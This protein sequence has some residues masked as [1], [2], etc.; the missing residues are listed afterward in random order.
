MTLGALYQL[1]RQ[2]LTAAGV[3]SPEFDAGFLLRHFLGVD[4]AG[5]ILRRE[6][7]V[8]DADAAPLLQALEMRA[9]RR[10]LQYVA[11]VWPFMELDLRVGEGV[12]VPRE[13]TAVLVRALADLLPPGRTLTGVDLCAGSGA[14]ALGLCSL[15]PDLSVTAVELSDAA[16]G[17]L[18][19]NAA[20]YPQYHVRP[21]IGDVTDPT[22]AQAFQNLE[23]IASNPPY[24]T[25]AEYAALQ[26]EVHREPKLALDGGEDGLFF[27]RAI[28]MLWLPQLAPGGCIGVEIGDTQAV[29][30]CALFSQSGLTGIKVHRDLSGH[31]RAVTARKKPL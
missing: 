6:E 2:R 12:L 26:P 21:V 13:D 19:Q 8:T 16:S 10:P 3:D 15:L 29:A 27:Y 28:C 23:F 31:D 9:G 24:V 4:R 18:T 7:T 25:P 20:A 22:C 30:V 17:Y 1:C 5:L 14:V 11:G